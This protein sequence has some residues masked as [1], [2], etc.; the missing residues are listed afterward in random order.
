MYKIIIL[1]SLTLAG[2]AAT[3]HSRKLIQYNIAYG[4]SKVSVDV[5]SLFEKVGNEVSKA[6]NATDG[7]LDLPVLKK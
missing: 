3:D 5:D 2:C 6:D 7:K 4:C 1:L